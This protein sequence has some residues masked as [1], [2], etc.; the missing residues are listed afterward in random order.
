MD[1]WVRLALMVV[2]ALLVLTFTAIY[3]RPAGPAR[4]RWPHLL[5]F[6]GVGISA[7]GSAGLKRGD[8]GWWAFVLWVVLLTGAMLVGAVIRKSRQRRSSP[9]G[10]G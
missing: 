6:L 10:T 4:L 9:S 2:G 8:W 1:T 3:D 5:L 7:Y